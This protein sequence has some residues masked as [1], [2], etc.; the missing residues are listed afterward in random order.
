[1]DTEMTGN[2]LLAFVEAVSKLDDTTD[3][4]IAIL[5]IYVERNFGKRKY[6]GPTAN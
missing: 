3:H 5:W 4:E 2:D 1:M 6:L